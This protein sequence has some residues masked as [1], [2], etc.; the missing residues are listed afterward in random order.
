MDIA[1]LNDSEKVNSIKAINSESVHK[2]C[3][4]QVVLSLAIAV[5]EL[6]ENSLDA[7]ATNVDIRFKNYGIDLIE[8]S[9][10]G[11]GVT[12]DNF[13]ALTLKY[14]TS[15][16]TDYSDLL[17]VT[18]FGFRGEALSSLCAL[19][20]L[21]IVTRHNSSEHA[22]KL[23]Y[24]HKGNVVKKTPCSRQVGT[25]VSLSNLF[26][27]LPVRQKEF[28][29]N[30]KR[31]FNKMTQLLYAYCLISLGVKITC[32]NQ[33]SSNSKTLV[34]AT[35]GSMSYKDNIACLFG[36]KQLQ[37]ILEIK[38]EQVSNIKQNI[39]KGLSGEVQESDESIVL[40][41]VDID[42]SEDSNDANQ[43][44]IENSQ[45][46][47]CSQK[48]QG[49]KNIVDQVKFTGF[50]S[51]CAHGSGRSS[52][53]RQF[54]YVNSRPCEPIKIIKIINETYKQY[55]P[56]QYPFVF[57]N[58]NLDRTSVDVNVTP[59]KRKLFLTK[60]KII[61]DV[62]K[63]SL[64]KLFEAIPRTLK[65]ETNS[66]LYSQRTIK[67]VKPETDQPR[68]FNSFIQRFA[69]NT[70]STSHTEAE[71]RKS[72]NVDLK[73]KSTTMLDYVSSKTSKRHDQIESENNDYVESENDDPIES[74]QND[75]DKDD[76]SEQF[77]GKNIKIEPDSDNSYEGHN[78]T[79]RSLDDLEQTSINEPEKAAESS[80]D[81]N[82]M[83]LEDT[84]NLPDTQIR[85]ITDVVIEKSHK[86]VCNKRD[87][88][89][90]GILVLK[91]SPDKAKRILTD[92]EDLGKFNRKTVK[93]K[94][95][96]EH[97]KALAAIK[98]A[99]SDKSAPERVKFKTT[100]NP[101]FNK[102][103]EEEL[104]KEISQD[105][106]KKMSVVGQFN[107]G[108]IITQLEDDL[109]IID[110]HATDEIY[111]FE[112]LQKTTDLTNQKL[113]IPQQLEL[114]GVNE[115][116]LMDNLEIFKKNGFTFEINGDAPPTRRVK[117]LT[118]PM[119]KNW[120]FGKEDIEELLFMLR[121][122]SSEYCR[123]SRVRAMFAS[124]ACRKSVMI[125]TAL[126][127]ADMKVLVDH[128]AEID[129]PWNCP[130]GRPTIRHL[131]NLAMVHKS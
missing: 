89:K 13:A 73:R 63:A 46:I 126:G 35:Q 70:A 118:I 27:S 72:K 86:I 67:D 31:E 32:S 114:T 65:V 111:N 83:Y 79:I 28:H 30:A 7:G 81:I 95:S 69:K 53:D 109:F 26:A 87:V 5:K 37:S 43:S 103:C 115:Q 107:L 55:N 11:S 18:S 23:E 16:L 112:T 58:I 39:F 99:Q 60:E 56:H 102:K 24:D 22:T 29:K 131:V 25:T 104:S 8:V 130:H 21:V 125:G 6:V 105:S 100:I 20:N 75:A 34:V 45:D 51:S 116:I 50:I 48:S 110:Q 47:T 120:I 124:R 15:K 52:T 3:S 96:L 106:F 119:S 66:T 62:M 122:S 77:N 10:N 76:N 108:F 82:I 68:I 91:T 90:N 12:E 42:L 71:N 54:F 85:R 57:L 17:G 78:Y 123:P 88:H 1:D 128:M 38:P 44:N 40:E 61:L 2:I 84:D 19:A 4:G 74:D 98:D 80:N 93:M 41:D 97:V 14:H 49:Y 94:T 36:H 117:L 101:V 92:K 113:V 64:F 9:D 129:N 121:E 59:D 127:K 33:T